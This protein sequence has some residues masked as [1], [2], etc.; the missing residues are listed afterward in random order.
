MS[1]S[2]LCLLATIATVP[3]GLAFLFAPEATAAQYAV[4]GWTPGTLV[5][6]RL[7]GVTFVSLGGAVFAVRR[8]KDPVLQKGLAVVLGITSLIA[9]VVA[10]QGVTVGAINAVGWSTVA[11]YAFFTLAWGSVALRKTAKTHGASGA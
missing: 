11:T 6:A 7:F 2:L 5:V 8:S 9:T 4:S 10:V 1:F 3:F